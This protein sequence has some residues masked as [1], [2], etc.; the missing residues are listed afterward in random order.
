MKTLATVLMV[1]ATVLTGA[2]Q[3]EL[4]QADSPEFN[5]HAN[6]QVQMTRAQV[7]AELHAAQAA[8]LVR[9]GQDVT[10]PH[11]RAQQRFQAQQRATTVAGQQT[12]NTSASL[13]SP[14]HS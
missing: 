3:A 11:I 9:S 4:V 2:A 13:G 5:T 7:V 14:N 8:G 12:P 10:Y 1:S 6:T